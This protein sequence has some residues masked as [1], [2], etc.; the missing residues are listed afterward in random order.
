MFA[1]MPVR[2]FLDAGL[3]VWRDVLP[4]IPHL[5]QCSGLGLGLLRDQEADEEGKKW[6]SRPVDSRA[7]RCTGYL[8]R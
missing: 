8:Q 1:T 6:V 5:S 3:V 4:H 2:V 7:L